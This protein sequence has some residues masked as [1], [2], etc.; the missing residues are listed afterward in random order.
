M[1]QGEDWHLWERSEVMC[2]QALRCTVASI[3]RRNRLASLLVMLITGTWLLGTPA[4]GRSRDEIVADARHKAVE[5]Q[6]RMWDESCLLDAQCAIDAGRMYGEAWWCMLF[7]ETSTCGASEELKAPV[8]VSCPGDSNAKA[9]G[10]CVPKA[11]VPEQLVSCPEDPEI[12]IAKEIAEEL[13]IRFGIEGAYEYV[14]QRFDGKR[15]EKITFVEANLL[16]SAI[17]VTEMEYYQATKSYTETGVVDTAGGILR[18]KVQ[19]EAAADLEIG[20]LREGDFLAAVASGVTE[21]FVD[22]KEAQFFAGNVAQLCWGLGG[23]RTTVRGKPTLRA[24]WQGMQKYPVGLGQTK[25]EVPPRGPERQV[26]GIPAP[27]WVK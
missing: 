7:P 24:I 25:I 6:R 4:F 27:D 20:A 11:P 14:H 17:K 5:A 23:G 2:R 8:P 19:A 18:R 16:L 3:L 21:W 13:V 12:A 9:E 15:G 22:S 26:G 10:D 1:Q